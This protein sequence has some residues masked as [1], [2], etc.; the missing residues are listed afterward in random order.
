MVE[1]GPGGFKYPPPAPPPPTTK[2]QIFAE[3]LSPILL[4]VNVEL[5]VKV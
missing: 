3:G 2:D 5:V 4:T 1:A